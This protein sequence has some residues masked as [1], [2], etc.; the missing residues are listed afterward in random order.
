[1]S[2]PSYN[3]GV[4][5]KS[6]LS[7]IRDIARLHNSRVTSTR[8]PIPLGS[9]E[10][11]PVVEMKKGKVQRR[12]RVES[13]ECSHHITRRGASLGSRNMPHSH[14]ANPEEMENE[15]ATEYEDPEIEE[16]NTVDEEDDP[17]D[18]EEQIDNMVLHIKG[19]IPN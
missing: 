12:Q 6:V 7:T 19:M 2:H 16:P 14:S 8:P 9:R 4:D 15:S 1:M 18:M 13:T 11:A 10:I 17:G 5:T 3:K